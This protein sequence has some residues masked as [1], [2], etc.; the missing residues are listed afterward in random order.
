[1]NLRLTL[2]SVAS[3][4]LLCGTVTA[5][6]PTANGPLSEGR[7]LDPVARDNYL[8]VPAEPSS[9]AIARPVQRP[10]DNAG[11]FISAVCEVFLRNL[12]IPLGTVRPDGTR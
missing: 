11:V 9:A 8:P 12:T 4:L 3:V 2:L 1:M 7:E 10:G 5:A 6:P